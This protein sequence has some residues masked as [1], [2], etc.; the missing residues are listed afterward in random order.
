[1][2]HFQRCKRYCK[3][4]YKKLTTCFGCYK[5]KEPLLDLENP[6]IQNETILEI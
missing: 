5:K 6:S 3:K 1:M 4:M 2:S